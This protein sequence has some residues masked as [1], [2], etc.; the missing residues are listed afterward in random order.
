MAVPPDRWLPATAYPPPRGFGLAD[1]RTTDE[2]TPRRRTG[3]PTDLPSSRPFS[4]SR[5]RE[6][7]MVYPEI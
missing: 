1:H 3:N 4:K 7:P 2:L 5:M 6:R